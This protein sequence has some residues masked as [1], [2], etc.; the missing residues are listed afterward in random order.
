MRGVVLLLAAGGGVRL[1]NDTP[2]AFVELCGVP[3]LRRA[4]QAASGADLVD[5][6][7]V[8]VPA[9]LEARADEVLRELGKPVRVVAGGPT[10]QASAVAALV[11][12]PEAEAVAV[13][14]AARA[15]CPSTLFDVCLRELDDCEAV[16]PA[17]PVADTIKELS[18]DEITRTLDRTRLAA[19]Q[20]PQTFRAEV[21]RRA[22]EAAARDGVDATDD[23]AL[24]E[25]LGVTVRIVPGDLGNLKITTEQ[26]L[27]IAEAL[28]RR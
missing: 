12:A 6:L 19:A 22:H 16:C 23:A 11:E 10:R 26:D 14:D 9:G 17:V 7:V 3:I 5:A 15:L 25:R 24:V 8:A 28:L 13:H 27:A 18:E 21:Y 1:D 2:K 20:T 4:A